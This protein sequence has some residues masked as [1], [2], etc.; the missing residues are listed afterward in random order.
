MRALRIPRVPRSTIFWDT[1]EN[2][3]W[4]LMWT[5]PKNARLLKGSERV[6]EW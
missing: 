5:S 2:G 4:W 1:D 3:T 6:E